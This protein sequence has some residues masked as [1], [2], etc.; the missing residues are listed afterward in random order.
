[1]FVYEKKTQNSM[2]PIEN[3][4]VSSFSKVQYVHPIFVI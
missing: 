4:H 2:T 3:V 1:M